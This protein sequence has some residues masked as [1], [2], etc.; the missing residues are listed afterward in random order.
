MQTSVEH[1]IEQTLG[2]YRIEQLLGRGKV[3]AVYVARHIERGETVMLT[4][5]II[6]PEF[7]SDARGRYLRRFEQVVSALKVLDHP[8]ILPVHDAGEQWGYPYIVTPLVT[9]GSLA[10]TLKQQER[11]S[12]AQA[13]NLLKQI[14]GALDHAHSRGISHG[15]LKPL[16]I[17]LDDALNVRIA[18]FGLTHILEMRGIELVDRPY[19]HLYSVAH[20]FLGAPEYIAPEVVLGTPI[21][22][23]SDIY[24]LG[25][26]LFEMLT[27]RVPFSGLDPLAV[28]MMH[29]QQPMPS[30]QAIYPEI[31]AGLDL[32][33]QRALERDPGKRYQ[34]A[35]QLVVAFERVLQVIEKARNPLVTALASSSAGARNGRDHD[36]TLPPVVSF[37]NGIAANDNEVANRSQ[38]LNTANVLSAE[39]SRNSA[40]LPMMN[41]MGGNWQIVPPIITSSLPAIKPP[42]GAQSP[43]RQSPMALPA[44]GKE[45]F[46]ETAID[47]FVWAS[48]AS[49]LATRQPSAVPGQNA[50]GQPGTFE[51]RPPQRK[52][53][54]K[55]PPEGSPNKGKQGSPDR[56]RRRTVALLAGGG[57]AIVGLLSAGGIVLAHGGLLPIKNPQATG[58]Q[59]AATP[60]QHTKKAAT[61]T[62]KKQDTK[63]PYQKTNQPAQPTKAAHT[64]TVIGAS[65]QAAGSAK[66]FNNPAD[67]KE[68]LLVHLTNGKF[69]AYERAC[70]HQQVA[71]D[72]DAATGHLICPLHHS[73]FDPANNGSVLVG[74]AQTPLPKVAIRVNA[75]GTI[76]AG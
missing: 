67:G 4:A 72:Y 75:D 21:N 57:V 74:P 48:T 73:V 25:I 34:S 70:T 45:P 64:G 2:Y 16:N 69:V 68:S 63:A 51:K 40:K 23:R 32:V 15:I 24:A 46:A 61:S 49:V 41:P 12:P 71:V 17:M 62:A 10:R 14:A 66:A 26:I 54:Q 47:P 27:G 58:S 50:E 65:N 29:I 13:L 3:N 37:F 53:T 19:A 60:T 28:A 44:Q 9:S 30:I 42:T 36:K 59:P 38:Q 56:G 76:T 33:V 22:A 35:E 43:R 11:V 1:L 8:H 55:R 6:P 18:G 31:P 20:T 52:A 39:I 5:F 7:S